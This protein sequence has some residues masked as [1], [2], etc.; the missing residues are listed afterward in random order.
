M[1]S[2]AQFKTVADKAVGVPD[3]GC[4]QAFYEIIKGTLQ[5]RHK[6]RISMS[7][8]NMNCALLLLCVGLLFTFLTQVAGKWNVCVS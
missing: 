3:T 5:R 4:L 6:L 1:Q 7:M 2:E 8:V